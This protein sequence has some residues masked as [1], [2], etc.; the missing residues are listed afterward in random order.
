LAILCA[1]LEAC[2]RSRMIERSASA[3]PQIQQPMAEHNIM[4]CDDFA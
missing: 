4:C 2:R 1:F 3:V